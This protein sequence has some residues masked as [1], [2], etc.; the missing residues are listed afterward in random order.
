MV[1]IRGSSSTT[2]TCTGSL[3]GLAVQL[4]CWRRPSH[5]CHIASHFVSKGYRTPPFL[6]SSGD[7]A[8]L[9][10]FSTNRQGPPRV[11]GDQVMYVQAVSNAAAKIDPSRL[12]ISRG[13]ERQT[14]TSL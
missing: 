1:R 13:L 8:V 4:A 6:P 11:G 3:I 5:L 2:R 10:L 9:N 12:V 7:M 14:T